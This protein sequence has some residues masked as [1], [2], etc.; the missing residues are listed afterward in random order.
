MSAKLICSFL[1]GLAGC[2]PPPAVLAPAPVY[3][4]TTRQLVR[5]DWDTDGDGRIEHRTYVH[6]TVPFRSEIDTNSDGRV[7]LWEYVG[8]D[9]Q[10][11]RVGRSSAGDGIEDVWTWASAPGGEVRV[12]HAQY[13]DGVADRRE[14]FIQDVLVRAEEDA[15]RDGRIDKWETWDGGVLRVAAFDTSFAASRPDRRVV[16]EATGGV[17]YMEADFNRDG[18]FERMPAAGAVTRREVDR[19]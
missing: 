7:D 9:G 1:V 4:R 12:D 6:G 3:E 2:A 11:V 19:E 13:R 8:G 17:A 5:L 16:Y 18:R 14:F 15:N 10:V